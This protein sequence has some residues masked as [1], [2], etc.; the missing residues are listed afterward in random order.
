[1]VATGVVDY[2]SPNVESV[3]DKAETTCGWNSPHPET[4]CIC[5][6]MYR[7][8]FDNDVISLSCGIGISIR[9]LYYTDVGHTD[10]DE[11]RIGN[12]GIDGHEVGFNDREVVVV[13]G[14]DECCID[15]RVYQTHQIFLALQILVRNRCRNG[16]KGS[17][18]LCEGYIVS[19]RLVDTNS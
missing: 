9:I 19:T 18:Y 7:V 14:E 17:C 1:M 4:V 5:R 15:A 8:C 6:G 3:V 13:D 16:G 2:T 10:S 11:N 12:V